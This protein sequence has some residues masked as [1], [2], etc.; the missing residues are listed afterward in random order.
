MFYM[1]ISCKS[2]GSLHKVLQDKHYHHSSFN[3][4]NPNRK[5]N[6]S[7][8]KSIE[9]VR[10]V[11]PNIKG[12][13]ERYRHILAKHKVSVFF[14]GTS[15]IESLLMYPKDPILDAQKTDIIYH[16][17]CPAHDCKTEY[18]GNPTGHWKKEFRTRK[19]KPPAPSETTTP[20]QNTQK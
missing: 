5:P 18:K 13:S 11:I 9:G 10:V 3:K 12:L 2:N 20:P 16:W 15:T 8:E 19:I 17:K 7:A 14:K 4:A 6:P 1:K